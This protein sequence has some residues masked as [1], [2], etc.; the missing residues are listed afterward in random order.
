MPLVEEEVGEALGRLIERNVSSLKAR[1]G[2][3]EVTSPQGQWL[4]QTVFWLVSGKILR[5][6][7]VGSFENLD[8]TDVEEVFRRVATHYGTEPFAAGSQKKLVALEESAR[9][10]DQFSS[11]A[12]TTTESL[13]YVYENTLISKTTRSSLGTHSTP[14]FLVD[15]IVGH[16]AN[17]IKEIP[18]ND[19]SVFEPACG[20]AAFLVSAMRLLAELLP[21]EKAVVSW[22]SGKWNLGCL[23]LAN[24]VVFGVM[25]LGWLFERVLAEGAHCRP[26]ALPG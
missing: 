10:I 4:L 11:L 2:W 17:W 8:L 12:L 16:L 6:K 25:L 3:D 5:D 7:E 20:H 14:S 24:G 22:F 19:R 13:A 18:E 21:P 1:L 26:S 15:Y 9:T 23:A